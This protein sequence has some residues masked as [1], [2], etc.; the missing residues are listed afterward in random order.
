M[1]HWLLLVKLNAQSEYLSSGIWWLDSDR[2]MFREKNRDFEKCGRHVSIIRINFYS[3]Y[4]VFYS[5]LLS[6]VHSQTTPTH[7]V[8]THCYLILSQ[9]TVLTPL[10]GP[11]LYPLKVL[12]LLFFLL[13]PLLF[14]LASRPAQLTHLPLGYLTHCTLRDLMTKPQYRKNKLSGDLLNFQC[15]YSL[16]LSIG[17]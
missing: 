2:T 15:L 8:C 1:L 11:L 9:L 7:T 3:H 13:Y 4:F 10:P 5:S 12:P 16:F 6:S 14:S 17:C